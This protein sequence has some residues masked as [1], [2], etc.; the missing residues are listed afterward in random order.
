[1]ETG[2]GANHVRS[3]CVLIRLALCAVQ[4][5][6]ALRA[7]MEEKQREIQELEALLLAKSTKGR[8]SLEP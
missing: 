4:E 6:E 7:Q 2:N 8:V 1:M 3:V 5:V